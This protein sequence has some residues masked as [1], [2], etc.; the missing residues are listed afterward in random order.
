PALAANS[1]FPLGKIVAGASA[2]VHGELP[3]EPQDDG[4]LGP[5]DHV[6]VDVLNN[7]V[8]TVLA[9]FAPNAMTDP[10]YI[11]TWGPI[12]KVGLLPSALA[13]LQSARTLGVFPALVHAPVAGSYTSV[14]V[15][16]VPV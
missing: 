10:L 7:A 13:A 14:L 8:C 1:T 6:F 15:L 3:P 12:S 11:R 16:H 4:R 5:A 2:R 9:V